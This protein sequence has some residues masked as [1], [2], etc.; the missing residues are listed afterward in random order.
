LRGGVPLKLPESRKTRAL[1]GLL[2]AAPQRT[3]RGRLADLLWDGADDPR[4]LLRWSLCRLRR[5]LGGALGADREHAWLEPDAARC[6]LLEL[7]ALAPAAAAVPTESLERAA[8]LF[9]GE[10]LEGLELPGCHAF[11]LWSLGQRAALREQR[12]AI[13]AELAARHRAEPERA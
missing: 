4:G 9:R 5:L 2:A 12:A 8:G 1:L 6:D 10:L 3:L 7:R 13:L 11:H